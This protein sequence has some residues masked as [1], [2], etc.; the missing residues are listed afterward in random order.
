LRALKPSR[1]G[2]D[3][4][5]CIRPFLQRFRSFESG[6]EMIRSDISGMVNA[7]AE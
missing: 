1:R 6:D 5:S 4:L 3:C 2:P 7:T